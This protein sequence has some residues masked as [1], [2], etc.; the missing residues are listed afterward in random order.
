MRSSIFKRTII[1]AVM[2]SLE[3]SDKLCDLCE[4]I[5]MQLFCA[6]SFNIQTNANITRAHTLKQTKKNKKHIYIKLIFNLNGKLF[7]FSK[8][9][10]KLW[11]IH[12]VFVYAS[13]ESIQKYRPF[14]N[15]ERISAHQHRTDTKLSHCFLTICQGL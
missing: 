11:N 10:G 15:S 12:S 5:E 3:T 13:R 2:R 4:Y 14:A 8:L 6:L 1:L 9:W 7:C